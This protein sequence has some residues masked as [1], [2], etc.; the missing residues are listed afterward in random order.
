ML[1]RSYTLKKRAISFIAIQVGT[2]ALP[3]LKYRLRIIKD[4]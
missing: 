3:G 1:T 2:G 4:E